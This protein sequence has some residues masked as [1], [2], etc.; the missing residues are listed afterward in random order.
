MRV[1]IQRILCPVDFSEYSN[2]A[3]RYAESLAR[4]YHAN[5]FVLNVVETWKFPC[6]C[7]A[8]TADEYEKF[9]KRLL[10]S[11]TEQAKA[12]IER[13]SHRD[14]PPK[15]VIREGM[16][17]G[18]I[19]AY[20]QN[21]AVQL[22]VMGTHG[23]RGFDRVILG[24]VTEKVLRKAACSVLAV[25]RTAPERNDPDDQ[26]IRLKNILFCTDFSASSALA[27]DYALSVAA[28]YH[29]NLNVLHV[30]EGIPALY[31]RRTTEGAL[32]RL[33]ALISD[34]C[35]G[36]VTVAPIVRIGCAYREISLVACEQHTDLVIMA[37]HGRNAI[38]DIVFGSTTY[39][40]VC[41]GNTPVL[42]VHV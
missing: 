24:S 30:Q 25:H 4:H 15:L 6:A 42:A 26:H 28:E 40:V 20:A 10:V 33:R 41:L 21:E 32:L 9:C 35:P 2:E 39:R 7:F 34:R 12:F 27:F 29:A 11:A 36:D 13:N 38:D 17:S 37:V 5:L 19:L 23:M 22:I 14:V 16:A 31:T 1:P 3:Y 18:S 8:A